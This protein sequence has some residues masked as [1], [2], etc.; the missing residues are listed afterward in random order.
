MVTSGGKKEGSE[1]DSNTWQKRG[2]WVPTMFYF[3]TLRVLI[4]MLNISYS[5]CLFYANLKIK[6]AIKNS[7]DR[8]Y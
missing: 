1:G 8:N 2:L 3:L 6:H 5:T 7:H 4:R